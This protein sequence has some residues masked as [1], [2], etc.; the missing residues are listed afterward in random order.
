MTVTTSWYAEDPI[1]RLRGG[2]DFDWRIRLDEVTTTVVDGRVTAIL[3]LGP[4]NWTG[5]S[6]FRCSMASFDFGSSELVSVTVDGPPTD[7]VL[8]VRGSK[9]ATWRMQQAGVYGGLM[10][11][12]G[13]AP[14]G[15]DY[16]TVPARFV[17]EPGSTAPTVP[18]IPD[19]T[20]LR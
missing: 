7:G 12:L 17:L 16:E 19:W 1:L 3:R 11:I 13:K 18:T 15:G 6:N 8:A 4:F 20:V 2:A 9:G 5:W 14:G 10:T